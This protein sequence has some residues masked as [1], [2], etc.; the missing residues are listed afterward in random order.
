MAL[1]PPCL[2]VCPHGKAKMG[3]CAAN[4]PEIQNRTDMD[5]NTNDVCQ[6]RQKEEVGPKASDS[7]PVTAASEG[8]VSYLRQTEK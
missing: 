7:Q 8:N 5:D 4:T 1:G 6:V 2:S 3:S